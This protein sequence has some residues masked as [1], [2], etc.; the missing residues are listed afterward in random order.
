[1]K[2]LT[3]KQVDT[4]WIACDIALGKYKPTKWDIKKIKKLNV[5]VSRMLLEN[6][7]SYE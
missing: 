5:A 7:E 4:A 1:M 6:L 2:K 3:N